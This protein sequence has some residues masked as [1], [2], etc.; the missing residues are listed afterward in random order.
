[1]LVRQQKDGEE[2]ALPGKQHIPS[3][4]SSPAA[5]EFFGTGAAAGRARGQPL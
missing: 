3:P 1:M 2:T 4:D 5:A